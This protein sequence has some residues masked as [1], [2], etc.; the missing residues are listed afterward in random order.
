MKRCFMFQ[1]GTRGG[2]GGGWFFSFRRASFLSGDISFD[3]G[4][5]G[6]EKN[7]RMG[8]LPPPM[9]PPHTMGNPAPCTQSP[10]LVSNLAIYLIKASKMYSY[11][12]FPKVA[13]VLE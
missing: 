13:I 11:R 12:P 10:F 5:G 1:W 2:G 3:G 9:P 6:F 8:A 7:C 4:G